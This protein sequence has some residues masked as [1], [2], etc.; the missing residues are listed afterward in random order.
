MLNY[1]WS[2][3]LLP[4]MLKKEN[5]GSEKK[6]DIGYRKAIVGI[7]WIRKATDK[8]AWKKMEEIFT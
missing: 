4:T 8:E 6:G 5:E 1:V 3:I 2:F 7:E